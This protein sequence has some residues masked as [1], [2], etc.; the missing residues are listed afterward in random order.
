MKGGCDAAAITRRTSKLQSAHH[1]ALLG[2]HYVQGCA[3]AAG[4]AGDVIQHCVR[5]LLALEQLHIGVEQVTL[6]GVDVLGQ[7]LV[8]QLHDT[9]HDGRL[10]NRRRADEGSHAELV[11]QHDAIQL[12]DVHLVRRAAIR[13]GVRKAM[14]L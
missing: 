8:H 9:C 10:A 12:R 3:G 5:F 14:P 6:G 1:D 11:A 4:H 2:G 13:H 7:H